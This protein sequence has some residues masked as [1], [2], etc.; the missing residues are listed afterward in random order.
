VQVEAEKIKLPPIRKA[1]DIAQI[2][3]VRGYSR[4]LGHW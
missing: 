3:I 4:R 1:T 2:G